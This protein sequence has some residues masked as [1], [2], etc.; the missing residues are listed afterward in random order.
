MV[1]LDTNVVSE[2]MAPARSRWSKWSDR[3]GPHDFW[4]ASVTR[5]ELLC[6]EEL[7]PIGKK[8]RLGTSHP[9]VLCGEP[10]KRVL[11]FGTRDAERYASIAAGW[12]RAGKSAATLDAQI[13]AIA[14]SRG[15]AVATRNIR[16]FTDCGVD[17]IN[18][19]EAAP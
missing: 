19:W 5:A 7:L 2:M 1:I 15:F 14:R 12:R 11:P 6:G 18:P 4:V 9:A 13:A 10:E 17:V 16:H 8:R 3:F